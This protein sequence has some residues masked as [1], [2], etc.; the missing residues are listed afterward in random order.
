MNSIAAEDPGIVSAFMAKLRQFLHDLRR[1]E[2]ATAWATIAALT[3]LLVYSYWPGLLNARSSWD[4]PQ[5]SHGWIVPLFTLGLLFW[6]R[7]PVSAEISP[8]ER[9]AGLGLLA[10]SF[11]LR[12]AVARYRIVTIDMYTF[13]PAVA[14]VF[15]MVGGWGM[16]RWAWAPIAFLMFMYPL[17]D[18]ATRYLLGPLQTLATM[19]STYALQTLGLDA[20]REGNQIILGEMHLGVVDACSG[21]RM[22]T[23]FVALSVA[24]VMLGDREWWENVVVIASAIPIALVVNSIRITVTGLLYQVASSEVA[25]MVFHDLAGWV[26]MPMALGMLFLLQQILAKLFFLEDGQLAPIT[27]KGL[28][29]AQHG[30]PAAQHGLPAAQRLAVSRSLPPVPVRQDGARQAAKGPLPITKQSGGR[31]V[32]PIVPPPAGRVP[33][34]PVPLKPPTPLNSAGPNSTGPN[35]PGQISQRQAPSGE[36]P[37]SPPRQ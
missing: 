34:P 12:L 10:A 33:Q 6:W 25:E 14:G 18:E 36:G 28:P 29:A 9:L 23:I 22:L 11:A 24:L 31:G 30:L 17:P 1:P 32:Q 8:W 4:N 21:L 37:Q 26:M 35:S 20:Y 3:G 2:E 27:A 15:L 5:Y 13:V 16:F 7:Q 19:V